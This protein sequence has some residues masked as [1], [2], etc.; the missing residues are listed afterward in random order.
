MS[1]QHEREQMNDY[2][3]SELLDMTIIQTLAE[4][5]FRASGL[6]MSII[7]A[8]DTSILVS[9]GWQDI[10]T[11]FHRANPVS[12]ARCLESDAYVRD[13]LVDGETCQYKCKNGLWHIAMPIVV[14]GQHLATMFLTQF[15]FEGEGP[16]REFF[17]RQAHEFGYNL[18]SYLE[19][20]DRMPVFTEEKV[21]YI[22][23]YDRALVRFISDLAERS[24]KIIETQKSLCRSEDKYRSVINNINI[25]IYRNTPGD[26]LFL[27]SNPAMA[28]M[29]GYDS[30]EEFMENSVSSTYQNPEDRIN[31]IREVKQNGFVKDRE[32][33]VRKKDG[34]PMWCSVTATAQYDEN[35]DIKWMDGVIEDITERKQAEERL[36]KTHGE[37]EMRVRER[38][39]DLAE[40]NELLLAEIAERKRVEEKLRELSE[41]DSLTMIHNR[42]KLLE[43]LGSEVEKAKR[44]SRPL[45]LIMLDIDHFKKVNDNYGHASGDSVLKTITNIVGGVIRK[46][47]I[48]A[49]YGGEEFIVL[50]PETNIEGAIVLAEKIRAAAEQ[51]SYPTVG[52]VTISAGVAELSDKDS[53]SALITKADAALYVAKQGGRNRV[54]AAA[55]QTQ[56]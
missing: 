10:C 39:A 51:Y 55:P 28:K 8:L 41:R 9:A 32:L 48:F 50:S 35:G 20:L 31:F 24:I 45:S 18:D 1:E 5:N 46:V 30:V 17:I 47:D 54:E 53:G 25:G 23:A 33:A 15:N 2:R 11:K 14:V 36:Q 16:D 21:N 38:T 37:L 12:H 40:A 26:G 49:R 29:F 4:S 44:Y 7:D 34:T 22:L 43:L 42:R 6:P 27:Q 13:R 3:L 56:T 52:K 19:A